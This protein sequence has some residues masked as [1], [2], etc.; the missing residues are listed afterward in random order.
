MVRDRF[1]ATINALFDRGE[2]DEAAA[3]LNRKLS[4]DPANHWVLTQ[5]GAARYEQ[6]NYAEAIRHL[7]ASL[8]VVPD[9]PLTLWH[10]AG[11]LDAVG[12]STE[13]VAIYSWLIRSRRSPDDD[14]CW[15]SRESTERL[16][17][18]C[19]YRLGVCFRHLGNVGAAEAC[20]RR[21]VDALLAGADG[22]YSL[23]DVREELHRLHPTQEPPDLRKF[24][25]S[26]L[27]SSGEPAA[28]RR[29]TK[30]PSFRLEQLL[31]SA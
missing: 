17:T 4:R 18:D 8:E 3:Q 15:E 30:P 12:K 22:L 27:A 14:P 11:A 10:L 23:D 2:W 13:A 28:V 29:S 26:A 16:K 7:V 9:C 5:L 25:E 6:R 19:V 24:V 31:P 21:Y 1:G 20:F